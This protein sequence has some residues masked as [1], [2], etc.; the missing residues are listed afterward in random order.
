M[1]ETIEASKLKI[2]RPVPG[3]APTVKLPAPNSSKTGMERHP[4]AVADVHD[5]VKHIPMSL[6]FPP[7][8]RPDVLV[9]SA[10]PKSSPQMVIDAYPL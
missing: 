5:D 2:G 1:P 3:M 9:G 8:S 7:C 10:T 6:A 4:K